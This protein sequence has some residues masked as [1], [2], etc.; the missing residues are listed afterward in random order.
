MIDTQFAYNLHL[1]HL[2][3]IFY[4]YNFVVIIHQVCVYMCYSACVEVREQF[5]R[6]SSLLLPCK[7]QGS[8]SRCQTWWHHKVSHLACSP[9]FSCVFFCFFEVGSHYVV[10]LT[11]NS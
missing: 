8:N 5:L 9:I 4:L 10:E 6:V 7:S 1:M 11:F 2:Q 3:M